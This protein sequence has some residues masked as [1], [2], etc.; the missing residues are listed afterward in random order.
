MIGVHRCLRC[1]RFRDED[2]RHSKTEQERMTERDFSMAIRLRALMLIG[3]EIGSTNRL[4]QSQ[5][6]PYAG[7]EAI[8]TIQ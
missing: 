8:P 4:Y 6:F 5:M 2:G 3:S 7:F 1:V